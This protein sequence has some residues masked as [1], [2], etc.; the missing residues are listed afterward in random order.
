MVLK[1]GRKKKKDYQNIY[2]FCFYLLT[3]CN[4]RL[5]PS[6]PFLLL[7][8]FCDLIK[9]IKI[10]EFIEKK[11]YRQERTVCLL[12]GLRRL[13]QR[14][15]RGT[16]RQEKERSIHSLPGELNPNPKP[17]P[18]PF[19]TSSSCWNLESLKISIWNMQKT[20]ILVGVSDPNIG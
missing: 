17:I 5:C 16:W 14:R 10:K 3:K 4:P 12:H 2:N 20:K 11:N 6:P 13:R 8:Y 1:I 19:Y 15:D 18:N 7:F 9:R